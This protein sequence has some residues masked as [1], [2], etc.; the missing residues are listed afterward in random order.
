MHVTVV[1]STVSESLTVRADELRKLGVDVLLECESIP[2]AFDL[3]IASPG[4]PARARI[5]EQARRTSAEVISEI[6]FAYRRSEAPWV[7]VTGTNGKT[8]VTSLLGHLLTG[9]GVAASVVGNIGTPAI[10]V[11]DEV[12]P[13]GVIVAEVSSFQLALTT[14]FAPR[15]SVL[16]NVTPDHLDYHGDMEQYAADKG[17]VFARQG[18]DDTAIIDRDDPGS[19]G[20]IEHVRERGIQVLEVSVHGVPSG[21]AGL[22]AGGMLVLDG[23]DGHAVLVH[24]DRLLIRGTHNVSNALAAAAAATALGVSVEDIRESL[25]TF[26]PIEHRLEPVATVA[27][28]EYFNDSKATNPDATAKAL[29][30]FEGRAVTVLLGGRNKGARFRDLGRLLADAGARV[31]VFGEAADEIL[32]DIAPQGVDYKHVSDLAAAVHAAAK[33]AAEGDAVVLSPACASFDEFSGFAERGRVFRELV[34][35]RLEGGA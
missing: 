30:A 32:A 15:V 22:D 29:E 12:G 1:D 25:V 17:R 14:T 35:A 21:G 11:V 7:A 26:A 34:F 3:A 6:E 13:A 19:A 16:L 28:V 24:R 5:M 9:A 31:V 18:V 10:S 2:G 33:Q 20:F 27:G 8:T 4:V 23:R